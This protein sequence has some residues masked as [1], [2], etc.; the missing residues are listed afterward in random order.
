[1]NDYHLPGN[2]E[3]DSQIREASDSKQGRGKK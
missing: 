3:A 1:M 2:D